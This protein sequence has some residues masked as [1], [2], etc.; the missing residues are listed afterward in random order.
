[1]GSRERFLP[2]YR[3]LLVAPDGR[4]AGAILLGDVRDAQRLR[5]L[6]SRD[7]QVPAELLDGF[8]E[9]PS[10]TVDE[11]DPSI[12]VCSCQNVSRGDIVQAIR[13]RKLTTVSEVAEHTRAA[14]GCGG[15]RPDLERLIVL[16]LPRDGS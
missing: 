9:R 10:T 1:M 13:D 16:A 7:Q 8:G 12:N 4:L 11:L 2:C 3:R 15:C 14:T 6:V 5:A